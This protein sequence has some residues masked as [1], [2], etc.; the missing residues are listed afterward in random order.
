MRRCMRVLVFEDAE[1]R[2]VS[3]TEA[4]Y[5]ALADNFKEAMLRRYVWSFILPSFGVICITVFEDS[6]GARKLEQKPSEHV[7]F[8]AHRRATPFFGSAGVRGEFIITH[9]VRGATC[10]LPDR[11]ARQCGFLLPPGLYD[12][13]G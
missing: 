5:V 13:Y 6:E 3:T 12:E 7:E 2:C 4:E 10:R 1:L 8:G 9:V 11:A